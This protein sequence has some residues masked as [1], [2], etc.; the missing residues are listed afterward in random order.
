MVEQTKLRWEE[1]TPAEF[2]AVIAERPIVYVP[3]GLLEW[4]GEH[5]PLGTDML[6]ING[7]V[8]ATA[9]RT[10]GII[11]PPTI[12]GRPGYNSFAGTIAFSEALIYNLLTELYGQLEKCGFKVIAVLTGHYGPIQVDLLRKTAEDYMARS[13]VRIIAQPEYEGIDPAPA[14]HAGKWETSYGLA[15]YPHLIQMDKFRPGLCPIHRYGDEW[16][17]YPEEKQDWIWKEDLR[18][19]SSAAMGASMIERIADLT[20]TKVEKA[21]AEALAQG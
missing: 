8:L 10:G 17:D 13:S 18:Q 21:L 15:L 11:M 5:L 9:R 12:Y 14:D 4:H 6:K 2:L 19:S 7:I 16:A 1:M 20:A 3:L